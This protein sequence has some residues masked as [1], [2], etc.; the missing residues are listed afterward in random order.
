MPGPKWSPGGEGGPKMVPQRL[1]AARKWSPKWSP[2]ATCKVLGDHLTPEMVPRPVLNLTIVTVV[3]A[4]RNH[5]PAKGVVILWTHDN[6][7]AFHGTGSRAPGEVRGG[8]G[9]VQNALPTRV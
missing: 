3:G 2:I 6:E 4:V 8:R 9:E 7:C 1:P 5:D